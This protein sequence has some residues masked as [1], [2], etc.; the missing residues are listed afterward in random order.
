VTNPAQSGRRAF[1]WSSGAFF[2]RTCAAVEGSSA[3]MVWRLPH[4]GVA[5]AVSPP[6]ASGSLPAPA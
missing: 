5:L 3:I 1:R 2:A 4:P 6:S